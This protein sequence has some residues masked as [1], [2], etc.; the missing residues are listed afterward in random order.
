MLVLALL[1]AASLR[2]AAAE[3]FGNLSIEAEPMYSETP[4]HGYLD[5]RFIIVNRSA[6]QGHE[7]TLE[8][9]PDG[10]VNRS[11]DLETIRR[12]VFVGPGAEVSVSLFQPCLAFDGDSVKVSIDGR[13]QANVLPVRSAL[14]YLRRDRNPLVFMDR[15]LDLDVIEEKLGIKDKESYSRELHVTES[16]TQMGKWPTSWLSYTRYD[17]VIVAAR[18]YGGAPAEVKGALVRYVEAG[19]SLLMI[20][21][22]EVPAPW[23][24]APPAPRD[25]LRTW[26]VGFGRWHVFPGGQPQYMSDDQW[27]EVRKAWEEGAYFWSTEISE[28]EANRRLPVTEGTAIPVR[29]MFLLIFAFT[30]AIGPINLWVLSRMKRKIWIFWTIPLFSLA[31]CAVIFG[32]AAFAEGWNITAKTVSFTVLDETSHRATTL[33]WAG[34]Y[35]PLT[36]S[37]GFRFTPDTEVT[38]CASTYRYNRNAR[39]REIDWGHVLHLGQGWLAARVPTHLM[40]RRCE[41]RRERLSTK[42]LADG[43]LGVVNGFGK[44]IKRLWLCDPKGEILHGQD[45]EP[46]QERRLSRDS[47][48]TAAQPYEALRDLYTNDWLTR[49]REAGRDPS[50]LLSPGT[51]LAQLEAA[52]FF[53]VPLQ[54]PTELREESFVFGIMKGDGE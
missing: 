41:I 34:F 8:F 46:G 13:L 24:A 21:D 28:E 35:S 40:V 26:A 10:S 51:Y 16:A 43:G 7:V 39:G 54:N 50:R 49:T 25:S 42:T 36:Y 32:Y 18:E 19:G 1:L 20:G 53:E 14:T 11:S 15:S 17:G 5:Y 33:A 27:H 44:R 48:S 2:P 6:A 37:D 38:L 47:R 4:T 52:P 23:S 45:L 3:T 31:T 9:S 29:A 30:L 22:G 12:V